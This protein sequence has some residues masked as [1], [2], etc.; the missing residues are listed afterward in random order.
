MSALE[1]HEE[2]L[3]LSSEDFGIWLESF[4]EETSLEPMNLGECP[5]ILL[6]SSSSIGDLNIN[7]NGELVVPIRWRIGDMSIYVLGY[8]GNDSVKA[9]AVVDYDMPDLVTFKISQINEI[10]LVTENDDYLRVCRDTEWN[11]TTLNKIFPKLFNNTP[12]EELIF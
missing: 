5:W 6:P 9:Y 7:P 2:I 12:N 1:K 8:D 11:P 3:A 10:L 4:E